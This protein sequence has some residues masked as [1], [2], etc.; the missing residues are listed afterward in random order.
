MISPAIAVVHT[1]GTIATRIEPEGRRPIG[2]P[3][4]SFKELIERRPTIDTPQ[5]DLRPYVALDQLSENMTPFEWTRIIASIIQACEDG[6]A[7]VVVTHGTDTMAYTCAAASFALAGIPIPVVFTGALTPMEQTHTDAVSNFWEAVSLCLQSE[8]GGVFLTFGG[9]R[10]V[11]TRIHSIRA[12]HSTFGRLIEGQEPSCNGAPTAPGLTPR[13]ATTAG[14]SCAA[15]A[16]EQAASL[17]KVHP[18]MDAR[19]LSAIAGPPIDARAIV[20]ELFHSG[21]ACNR[22]D[23]SSRYELAEQIARVRRAG[24]S[25]LGVGTPASV[26]EQYPATAELQRAGMMPLGLIT[27]EAA[28]VKAMYLLGRQK[29]TADIAAF[30]R[31]MTRDLAGETG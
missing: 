16:F 4:S 2:E 24:V 5:V 23:A 18:G 14:W 15:P 11:G 6:A 28:L 22:A 7:G 29:P 10:Y 21:T 31:D 12:G 26:A 9:R 30:E 20:L 27:P 19:F 3:A 1:G 8:W 13:Q 25:V 17:I